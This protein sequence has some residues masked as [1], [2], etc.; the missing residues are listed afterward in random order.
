MA[1]RAIPYVLLASAFVLLWNSGFIGAEYGLP[2]A[3]ALTLLFWRYLALTLLMLAWVIARSEPL[4]PDRGEAFHATWTGILAHAVWLGCALGAIEADVP[5]GIVAL[6]V[7]LQPLL[8]GALSG[9]ITGEGTSPLQWVGLSA[10]FCGVAVAV[11]ARMQGDHGAPLWAYV[12]PFGSVVAITIASLSQRLRAHS[13]RSLP[14][15]T[16]LL[17]QSAGSAVALLLPALLLEGLRTQWT[18]PF[19]AALG[20]VTV[21]VSLGAYALM[22][23]LLARVDATRVASLFYF[24]PPVTMLMAWLAFGDAVLLT[25]WIALAI[26]AVG[27]VLVQ[28]A[29][30]PRAQPG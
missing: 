25:D 19:I 13:G 16:L 28:R 3:G 17:Y 14:M 22:W 18:L 29:P 21:L 8:T 15:G 6:V 23:V 5:A 30:A 10:G 4:L 12:L 24:G 26:T 7:A 1:T 27:V 11:I 9:A 2:Y 20:W